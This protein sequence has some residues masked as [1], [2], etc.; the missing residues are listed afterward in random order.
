MAPVPAPTGGPPALRSPDRVLRLVEQLSRNPQGLTAKQLARRT[1][2]PLKTVYH[3][4]RTVIDRQ[5]A[6]RGEDGRH[7]FR[8]EAVGPAPGAV[9]RLDRVR[10]VLERLAAGT[11]A[12]VFLASLR[13][14]RLAVAAHAAAPGAVPLDGLAVDLP[15]AVHA[16]AMGRALLAGLPAHQRRRLLKEQ[17]LRPFTSRTVRDADGLEAELRRGARSGVFTETGEYREDVACAGVIVRTGARAS[18]GLA[19]AAAVPAGLPQARRREV[20]RRLRLAAADL[21]PI[22]IPEID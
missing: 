13:E 6:W 4:L 10:P 11:G 15:E 12:A 2:I 7:Y 14:D 17:G 19:L 16:T 5:W 22:L 21:V 9:P 3:H 8:P 18:D 20:D 1:G